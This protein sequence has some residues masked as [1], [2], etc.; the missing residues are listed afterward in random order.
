MDW[1]NIYQSRIVSPQE[2]VR[3]IKSGDRIFLTGNVSV[4]QKVLAA[5]V[6]YAPNL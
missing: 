5:L 6:D 1:N 4:P 3:S 2:A